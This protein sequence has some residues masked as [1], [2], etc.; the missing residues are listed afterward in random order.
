LPAL[1]GLA[2]PGDSMA[3]EVWHQ[4]AR[5]TLQARLDDASLRQGAPAAAVP[6]PEGPS[7]R[8]GL[9]LRPLRPEEKRASSVAAGLLVE[10]VNGAAARAGLQ[11]GDLLLAM[12]GRAV[13]SV[14]QVRAAVAPAVKATALLV[15]R[16]EVKLYVALRLD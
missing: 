14:E 7:G 11:A 3:L 10:G 16:G 8:L 13:T 4:G 1:V 12:D 2:Q 5:R 6:R 9:A 15:Q